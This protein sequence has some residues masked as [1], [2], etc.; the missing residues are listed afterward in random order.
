MIKLPLRPFR[1]PPSPSSTES[2]DGA[3]NTW[4]ANNCVVRVTVFVWGHTFS[5][6]AVCDRCQSPIWW[7]WCPVM[8]E[9]REMCEKGVKLMLMQRPST[10]DG[11]DPYRPVLEAS[12]DLIS[13]TYESPKPQ[14][15]GALPTTHSRSQKRKF[16]MFWRQQKFPFL[17]PIVWSSSQLAKNITFVCM[18][19]C[20]LKF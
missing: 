13:R 4:L 11:Q 6:V 5:P 20:L 14:I 8:C 10:C 19:T 16:G 17:L 3:I 1:Q 15:N 12:L 9:F 7:L 18:N 2:Y